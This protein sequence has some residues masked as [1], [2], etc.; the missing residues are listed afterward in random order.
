M[1]WLSISSVAGMWNYFQKKKNLFQKKGKKMREGTIGESGNDMF[2]RCCGGM[3]RNGWRWI[4]GVVHGG[5]R[6]TK[7]KIK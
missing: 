5:R 1:A 7:K 3:G 2:C 6:R 4:H